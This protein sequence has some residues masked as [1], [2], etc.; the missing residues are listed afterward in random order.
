MQKVSEKTVKF[1]GL[2]DITGIT[3]AQSGGVHVLCWA[4]KMSWRG[5]R[6]VEMLRDWVPVKLRILRV[7]SSLHEKR[8][9]LVR[10]E[11]ISDTP[12]GE[13]LAHFADDGGL[14]KWTKGT[15][16]ELEYWPEEQE[17]YL[18]GTF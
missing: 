8:A 7:R 14:A 15:R 12:A 1:R 18:D 11:I 5:S 6:C 10:A 16:I 4:M 13:L 3:D 9:Y 2:P 17:H